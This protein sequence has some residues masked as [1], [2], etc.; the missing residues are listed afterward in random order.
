[1]N[2]FTNTI[3]T[4]LLSWLKALINNIWR[5]LRSENGGAFYQFLC[6]NWKGIVAVLLVGGVV[7]DA[8]IYLIR[9]RPYYVWSSKLG[10]LH[11]SKQA[12]VQSPEEAYEPSYEPPVSEPFAP[13]R[14][15]PQAYVPPLQPSYTPQA[16]TRVF[17]PVTSEPFDYGAEQPLATM[18]YAPM[19]QG[20][21]AVP[22]PYASPYVPPENLEPVFDEADVDWNE[23]DPL[24][25]PPAWSNPAHDMEASFGTPQPEPLAYLRDMQA[26]FA[27]PLPPEQLYAP[28]R[29]PELQQEAPV[30]PGLDDAALRQ[31]FRLTEDEIDPSQEPDAWD[32]QPREPAPMMHAPKFHPFTAPREGEDQNVQRGRNPL[33]RFAKRARDLV[34]VEDDEHRPTIHD[35]Q[36]TVDVTRAFH[37]PVYPQSRDRRDGE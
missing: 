17:A 22:A 11:R 29:E 10:R 28:P 37:E 5:V 16:G 13:P 35:L 19:A 21:A 26:G 6:A 14:P 18:R 23:S 15:E 12:E 33:A 25:Q 36:S 24:V 31:N 20:A 30:H 34:G 2:G 9:W 27:R 3:L 7:A 1:M 4:L 8:I 32:D